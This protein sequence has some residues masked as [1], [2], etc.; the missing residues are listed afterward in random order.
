MKS[1][2]K[3]QNKVIK[4]ITSRLSKMFAKHL[5]PVW[6]FSNTQTNFVESRTY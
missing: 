5:N 3:S 2:K 6:N 1:I 4:M